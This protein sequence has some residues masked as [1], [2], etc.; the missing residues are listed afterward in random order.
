MFCFVENR[1]CAM[2]REGGKVRW[3]LHFFSL[4]QHIWNVILLQLRCVQQEQHTK[5]HRL[6]SWHEA[7]FAP[8]HP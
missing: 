2:Y 5:I 8:I 6:S 1:L 7:T 3:M 4:G